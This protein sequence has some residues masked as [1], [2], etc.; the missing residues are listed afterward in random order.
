MSCT[1]VTTGPIYSRI[2]T[3]IQRVVIYIRNMSV[4][5]LL[6][7]QTVHC[8][9]SISRISYTVT[10]CYITF[11]PARRCWPFHCA[12][13]KTQLSCR[14]TARRR[15]LKEHSH[16]SSHLTS[17]DIGIMTLTF[18]CHATSSMTSSFVPP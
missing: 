11:Y 16:H 13:Q 6:R 9:L 1:T 4:S 5:T 2:N 17:S 7:T 8:Q 18:H 15:A 3:A 14:G 12:V 10:S